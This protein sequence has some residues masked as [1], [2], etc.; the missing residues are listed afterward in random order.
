MGSH[1]KVVFTDYNGQDDRY[2]RFL[3]GYPNTEDGF[4]GNFPR[5]P[6]AYMLDTYVRRLALVEDDRVDR[7]DY[8]YKYHIDLG[9]R[10]VSIDSRDHSPVITLS[11][12]DAIKQFAYPDYTEEHTGSPSLIDAGNTL[13]E[14]LFPLMIRIVNKTVSYPHLSRHYEPLGI[15]LCEDENTYR[16]QPWTYNLYYSEEL[17]IDAMSDLR[18]IVFL[19]KVKDTRSNNEIPFAYRIF[20]DEEG[21]SLPCLNES[22]RYNQTIPSSVLEEEAN[23]AAERIAKGTPERGEIQIGVTLK[24]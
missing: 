12:A 23:L 13:F 7:L 3:D 2:V 21:F 14:V 16:F 4:F 9:K 15:L 8:Y 24:R 22:F 6:R 17:T 18:K 19:K 11:F 1:A 10:T 20:L 5:G